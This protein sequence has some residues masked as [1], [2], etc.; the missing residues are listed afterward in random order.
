MST[1]N[2]KAQ[3][4]PMPI[5]IYKYSTGDITNYLRNQLGFDVAV[6][7]RRWT[8]IT[9]NHSYVRMRVVILPKDIIMPITSNNF[10]DRILNENSAGMTFK[11]EVIETLKPYMY[12]ANIDQLKAHPETLRHLYEY[13]VY[14]DR[15]EEIIRYAKLDYSKDAGFF[16]LYLRPERIIA[17]ML[18]D[19]DTNKID[20]QMAI[21]RVLG[22]TQETFQWEIQVTSNTGL[23][24]DISID[25][26]FSMN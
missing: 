14:G 22:E 24:G 8:G 25:K 20:G 15:L 17:D 12:P 19:P 4:A 3:I 16:R 13:G 26:I 9:A 5:E 18:S 11:K 21:T 7:Y 23:S 10:T 6:D 1:R 2:T